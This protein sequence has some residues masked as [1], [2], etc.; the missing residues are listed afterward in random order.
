MPFFFFV[1]IKKN[2][3]Y[4]G[5]MKPQISIKIEVGGS[6]VSCSRKENGGGREGRRSSQR[7]HDSKGK[8][9]LINE[10]IIR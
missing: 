10:R 8:R 4:L 2:K 6:K 1:K 5:E 9:R 7:A 3:K